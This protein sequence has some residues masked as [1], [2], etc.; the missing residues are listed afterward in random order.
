[1]DPDAERTMRDELEQA[2]GEPVSQ[3]EARRALERPA[4]T[5]ARW[6]REQQ[7]EVA[8]AGGAAIV[9]G[10]ILSLAIGSWLLLALALTVHAAV[11]VLVG[12][13]VLRVTADVDKP[14]PR[15][16]ARLQAEGVDDPESK[17][18][19][20][21][22][23]HEGD[24]RDRVRREFEADADESRT[25]AAAQ[26]ASIT[27]SSESTTPVGPGSERRNGRG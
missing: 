8:I 20:A 7:L 17:L 22:A 27:P 14:D 11:T 6:L 18:N 13:V 4:P 19:R 1:M 3:E 24:D 21:I 2:L 25:E 5:L 10:A 12:Y 9:V 23:A 15:T 26:Q 16:V